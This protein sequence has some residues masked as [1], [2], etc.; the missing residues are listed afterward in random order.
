VQGVTDYAIYLLTPQ[1]N[2][3][4]WNSGAE[5]IKGYKPEEIIGHHFST[6]YTTEDREAGLPE[7]ALETARV[8]G[9]FEKEGLRVRK[10]GSQ[11]FASVVIDAIHDT[12]GGLVGFAKIT[13]DITER[14]KPEEQLERTREALIQSQKLEAIG[15]L[16]GGVAHDFNNLLMAIQGSDGAC[17]PTR[18]SV[19]F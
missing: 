19:C 9:R 7:I 3:S 15:H 5:R 10:D 6:F 12:D 18:S 8:A 16:T 17:R 11:F 14:K 4:S 13:R 2:V 1:G